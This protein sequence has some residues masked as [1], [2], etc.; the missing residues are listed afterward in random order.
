MLVKQKWRQYFNSYSSVSFIWHSPSGYWGLCVSAT[1]HILQLLAL[2]IIF[3]A[4]L[5][6][7]R[8]LYA[9]IFFSWYTLDFLTEPFIYSK[10]N[11]SFNYLPLVTLQF[12]FPWCGQV[13]STQP[14]RQSYFWITQPTL[15]CIGSWHMKYHNLPSTLAYMGTWPSG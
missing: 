9:L 3:I 6:T 7:F 5:R 10:F 11:L 8:P 13:L 12:F 14:L 1:S 15:L 4:I 2:C